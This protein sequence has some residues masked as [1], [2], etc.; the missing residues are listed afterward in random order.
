[1]TEGSRLD[2]IINLALSAQALGVKDPDALD[3]FLQGV[4]PE[5]I[6]FAVEGAA[7]GL[8]MR[9][10]RKP[11]EAARLEAFRQGPWSRYSPLVYAGIGL[12]LGEVGEPVI[13]W[14]ESQGDLL[15][16][17]ALDGYGF[18][19]GFV[20]PADYLGGQPWPAGIAGGHGAVFDHGLARFLWFA[21]GADPAAVVKG[22][23]VFPADRHR[24]IWS[25]IAFAATYAGGLTAESVALLLDAAGADHSSSVALG[26]AMAAYVRV[27]CDNLVDTTADAVHA[28]TGLSA[29][30]AYTL[31]TDAQAAAGGDTTL[32]GFVAWREAIRDAATR[33]SRPAGG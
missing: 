18:H 24:D 23:T 12:G 8:V 26:A 3:G 21:S 22:A 16:G 7:M 10:H 9:R 20:A 28:L 14:A 33:G 31:C 1:V 32:A 17:F 6:G 25:G 30:E 19:I 13:P 5:F 4:D 15:A 27:L 11:E 2:S 29:A